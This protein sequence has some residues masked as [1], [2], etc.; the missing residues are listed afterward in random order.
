MEKQA[1][2]F[3]KESLSIATGMLENIDFS[4]VSKKKPG[5]FGKIL[6]QIGVI[7][8]EIGELI[9]ILSDDGKKDD[10]EK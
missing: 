2:I 3:I 10:E 1:V 7:I 5:K 8:K 6:K 9:I 4:K